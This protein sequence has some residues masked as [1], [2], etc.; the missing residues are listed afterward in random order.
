MARTTV[1]DCL[2][3]CPNHF[4]LAHRSA[5]R[6]RDIMTRGDARVPEHT[7]KPVVVALREIADPNIGLAPVP[8]AVAVPDPNAPV[9]P[10]PD[11]PV[12]EHPD[13]PAPPD[14]FVSE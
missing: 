12:A 6:A 10:P 4:E 1:D 7:D 13:E 3:Q 14:D 11:T 5:R 2:A 8:E 9:P